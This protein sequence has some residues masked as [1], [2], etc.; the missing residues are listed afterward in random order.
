MSRLDTTARWKT[1]LTAMLPLLAAGGCRSAVQ[2]FY[3]PL[4]RQT[5]C[6]NGGGAGESGGGLA[7]GGDAHAGGAG[8]GGCGGGQ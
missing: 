5:V 3:E 1:F 2:D 7:T 8:G 4:T 6:S